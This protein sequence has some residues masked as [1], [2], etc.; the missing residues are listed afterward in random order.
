D[1]NAILVTNR[2]RFHD[3]TAT[4]ALGN[5]TTSP[6]A[7]VNSQAMYYDA[8]NRLIASVDVGTNGGTA[9]TRPSS[10]PT[11]S[12]TVLVTSTAYNGAG[13]VDTTT[14]P[15]GLVSKTFYD[16]LGRRTKQVEDY[17]DGVVTNN[18]NKA[19]EYTYDGSGHMLTLQADLP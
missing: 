7:R 2:Q 16:N 12:D 3:E 15:K 14:D 9:Y 13:W 18:T 10:V 17:T 19:V 8:A 1:G 4:G 5:P 11:P 6:K